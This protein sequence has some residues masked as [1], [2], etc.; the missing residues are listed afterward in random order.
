MAKKFGNVTELPS[1]R[2]R[3]RYSHRG[4]AYAKTFARKSKAQAWLESEQSLIVLDQWTTPQSREVKAKVAA[5]TVSEFFDGMPEKRRWQST[6]EGVYRSM[7]DQ[8]I[9][10]TLGDKPLQAVTRDDVNAWYW[11]MVRSH[12]GRDKRNRDVYALLGTVFNQARKDGLVEVS[13]VDIEG[14]STRPPAKKS[15]DIPT[16]EEFAKIVL[17]VPA[18][19][20]A[21]VLVAAGCALRLGEWSA[22]QRKDLVCD[23]GV[24]KV[25]VCKQVREG[26]RAGDK[27]VV[28]H[29]KTRRGRWVTI[30][31]G[32]I[33]VLEHHLATYALPGRDGLVFPNGDGGWV[34]RRRFNRMLK[35]ACRSAVGHENMHSHLLRHYGGTMFARAGASLAETMARL[36]HTTVSAAMRYQHASTARDVEVANKIVMPLVVVPEVGAA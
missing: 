30:P 24:W 6:T 4:R 10:P 35:A 31:S 2:Y 18:R 28:S 27:E 17:Q 13:P 11:A 21:A 25:H 29:T 36:G 19:Y 14:A 1:G 8:H 16:P 7:F 9:A 33:P 12:K 20:K 32:C 22:L 3:A 23:G 5:M 34:D 15:E 26:K